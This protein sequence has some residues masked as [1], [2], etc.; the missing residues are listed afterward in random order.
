MIRIFHSNPNQSLL[1]SLNFSAQSLIRGVCVCCATGRSRALLTTT[2]PPIVG[3]HER[4]EDAFLFDPL[5]E[6]N[7]TQSKD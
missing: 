5:E 3:Q 7:I 1:L 4:I 2:A 6:H